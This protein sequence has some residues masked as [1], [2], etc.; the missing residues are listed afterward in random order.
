MSIRVYNKDHLRAHAGV[1]SATPDMIVPPESDD[2]LVFWTGHHTNNW[3]VDLRGF[4]DGV[5][6]RPPGARIIWVAYTGRP[7]LIHQLAPAIR[8]SLAGAAPRT[9]SSAVDS[10]R[11]W[12]RVLDEVEAAAKKAQQSMAR[13][14]DVRHLT[15][16][17]SEFA[18]RKSMRRTA[19]HT[20]RAYVNTTR[21]ALGASA[22]Y[23]P[24]PEDPEP[25][26]HLPPEDQ[27]KGLRIALKRAWSDVLAQW[28]LLDRL[29]TSDAEPEDPD[30]ADLYRHARHFRHMQEKY[31]K[32]LPTPAELRDGI[33]PDNFTAITNLRM[34][35]L[36][37]TCFPT[38]WDVDAAFHLCLANT[39]WNSATLFSLDATRD[40]LR[41]HPKDSARFV[42]TDET[43]ELVG[44]KARAG[45]KEQ[46]VFGLWKT[47]SGPGFIVQTWLDRIAPLREIL[48]KQ[49]A[50][51]KKYYAEITRNGAIEKDRARQFKTVQRLEIGCRSVWLYV[52]RYG[53]VQWLDERK[54]YGHTVEGARFSFLTLLINQLNVQRAARNELPI[55]LCTPSDFRHIFAVYVWRQSGGNILAVQR[56]LHHAHL[57]TSVT[58][59]D[60][61]ILNAGKDEVVR[62]FMNHLFA[63][64]GAGRLD[65]TIL[66]H[67]SKHGSVT[68]QMERR[69]KDY[70]ALSR[71]RIA[72]ACKDPRNPP[73]YIEPEPDGK[74]FCAIQRCLL[75]KSHAVILPESLTGIA[76]RV[77]ELLAMEEGL[78][79]ETWLNS[80][81]NGELQN[82]LAV[83]K[84]FPENEVAEE[85][86]RW[87]N[88][89]VSGTH[90]IPGL[91]FSIG[92]LEAS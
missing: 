67:L 43:Y 91:P 10:L 25:Q 68:P 44:K 50:A 75:C 59:L 42:L 63:E 9:A 31:G 61:N 7:Q 53:E 48:L 11:S 23:W 81:F 4:A 82:G 60:N 12:W 21:K 64:L 69:L 92:I 19:F 28:A 35:T 2:S 58:Y 18:H 85:R 66:A 34:T 90:H 84:L 41:T 57:S 79:T 38:R 36:R 47:T 83:L 24:A 13:V 71:S 39:G 87:K 3:K 89:I 56:A 78:P 29:L 54:P 80:N 55:S 20:F 14:D 26:R 46:V 70:R 86:T 74:S 72:V 88:A 32:P 65:V 16:V 1:D 6:E 15:D 52:D 33:D 27:A 49:L 45:G 77:E 22:V 8:D 40:I 73:S 30:H 17:H 76:Q 51:E 62:S 5:S 37:A